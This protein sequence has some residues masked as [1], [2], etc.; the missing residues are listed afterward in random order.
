MR[1]Q[2]QQQLTEHQEVWIVAAQHSEGHPALLSSGET[3]N[4]LEGHVS[5]H[6]EL[7]QHPP[8]VLHL[9]TR[10]LS[11]HHLHRADQVVNLVNKMLEKFK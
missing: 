2:P 3:L 7:A 6:S 11:L 5:G 9:L 1:T 10:E 4:L 8:V